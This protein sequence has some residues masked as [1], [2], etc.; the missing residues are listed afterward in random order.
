MQRFTLRTP[1]DQMIPLDD[2]AKEL[3]LE[4]STSGKVTMGN[5]KIRIE[6][7]TGSSLEMTQQN[8]VLHAAVDLR[9]EAPGNNIVI[10]AL[11]HRLRDGVGLAMG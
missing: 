10:K 8:V 4:D 7:A 1:G 11:V 2:E 3:V 6:D 9:I 5:Q